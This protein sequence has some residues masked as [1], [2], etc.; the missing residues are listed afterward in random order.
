M[1]STPL[2]LCDGRETLARPLQLGQEGRCRPSKIYAVT[3]NHHH[4]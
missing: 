1:A 4:H 2:L 3:L